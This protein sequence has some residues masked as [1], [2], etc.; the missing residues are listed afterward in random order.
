MKIY[1][2]ERRITKQAD[3]DNIKK[4]EWGRPLKEKV[5]RIKK[6]KNKNMSKQAK[7]ISIYRKI[8]VTFIV[9][10][11]LL[12]A[13]VVYF[14]IVIVKI[15][16]TPK[17]ERTA[18]SF[19]ATVKDAASPEEI[20]GAVISGLVSQMAVEAEGTFAAT[21]K[22]ID[23]IEVSGKVTVYNT[24][25]SAQP[26][27]KTTRLLS[28]DGKLFRLKDTINVPAGGQVDDV[29]V[30]ADEPSREMTIDPVKFTIPG[31]NP[32]RQESVYAQSAVKF[33]YVEKGE[34]LI[35]AED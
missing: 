28:P 8:A 25:R 29:A 26:L 11:L 16:I 22:E 18:A 10:T 19:I 23:G 15:I 35:S 7:P 30:Y 14:S 9:L 3:F 2:P 21:G 20:K 33:Q 1:M 13:V 31:L 6:I 27:V 32:V 34:T 4:D 24:S 5:N 12:A 17:K